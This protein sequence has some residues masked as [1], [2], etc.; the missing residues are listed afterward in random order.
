MIRRIGS[1]LALLWGIAHVDAE[2][3]V[4]KAYEAGQL[5]LGTALLYQMQG[6]RD[7]TE[8]PIAY[9]ESMPHAF[10]GTPH[11]VQAMSA[12]PHMDADYARRLG[13]LMQRRP[14]ADFSAVSPS[15]RFR[16]HYDTEGSE[17]VDPKETDANGVPDKVDLTMAVLD[18]VWVCRSIKWAIVHRPKM[19]E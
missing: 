13:K 9:Q 16:V 19:A 18:S 10:C 5:D 4:E 15:G 8:L 12:V 7:K 17:R 14:S 1:A 11:V 3:L 2:T 6:M